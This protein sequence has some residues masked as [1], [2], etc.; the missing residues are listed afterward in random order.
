[1]GVMANDDRPQSVVQGATQVAQGAIAAMAGSPLAIALLLVNLVWV[2][3]KVPEY[4]EA[5][6]AEGRR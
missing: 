4:V 2:Y 3:F 5:E 6:D 1:M